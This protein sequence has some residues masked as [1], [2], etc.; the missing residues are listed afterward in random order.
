[1]WT[2]IEFTEKLPVDFHHKGHIVLNRKTPLQQ[3]FDG[4]FIAVI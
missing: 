2:T 4:E 1:M 3:R